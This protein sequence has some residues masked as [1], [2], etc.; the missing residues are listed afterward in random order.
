VR[1]ITRVLLT[2]GAILIEV[3]AAAAQ[4]PGPR[5]A[6]LITETPPVVPFV[7]PVTSPAVMI[8]RLESFDLNAD[9]RVSHD[10]LPERMQRLVALGDKNADALL[11]SD[12]IRAL[13]NAASAEL[14]RL[15]FRNE[16]SEGLPGVINDLK[17][18]AAKH[19][20]ALA[21][22]GLYQSPSDVKAPASS[23]LFGEMK[24]LLDD[25]EYENFVAATT[26]L[27]KGRDLRFRTGGVVVNRV[28]KQVLQPSDKDKK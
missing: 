18:P 6:V 11:D 25:E 7:R 17:L 27:S 22:V 16:T 4:P 8:K 1:P 28:L 14:H 9:G 23:A 3:A 2:A 20:H 26:R 5:P 21:I 12:E 15:T 13:V 19:M 24:K 10:E